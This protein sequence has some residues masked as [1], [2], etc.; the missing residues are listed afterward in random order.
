MRSGSGPQHPRVHLAR[1]AQ[2]GA[3]WSNFWLLFCAFCGL[4]LT[5]PSSSRGFSP[6]SEGGFDTDDQCLFAL[7]KIVQKVYYVQYT[8]S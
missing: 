6:S 2:P 5:S 7:S 8:D 3:N 1:S 4:D